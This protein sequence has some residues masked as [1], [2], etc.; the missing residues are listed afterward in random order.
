MVLILNEGTAGSLVR[1][2]KRR[3]SAAVQTDFNIYRQ[4][5]DVSRHPPLV[6]A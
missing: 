6:T 5:S 4:F 1:R 3:L 2:K